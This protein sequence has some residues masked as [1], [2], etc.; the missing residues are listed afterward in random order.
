[1]SSEA[2]KRAG[3]P[4]GVR[5]S[6]REREQRQA[7]TPS[8]EPI[9]RI[10]RPA[11]TCSASAI[12]AS[13]A[14]RKEHQQPA[15]PARTRQ[16]GEQPA[17]EGQQDHD[18]R[19]E[20]RLR[21]GSPRLRLHTRVILE[22]ACAVAQQASEVTA[23]ARLKQSRRPRSRRWRGQRARARRASRA[24]PVLAP[25]AQLRSDS[26]Q[27]LPGRTGHARGAASISAP[28][29]ERPPLRA[30]SATAVASGGCAAL[31]VAAVP[32]TAPGLQHASSRRT[33]AG[34]RRA[35][36]PGG[37][38]D[39][40]GPAGDEGGRRPA[41]PRGACGARR[42]RDQRPSWPSGRFWRGDRQQLGPSSWPSFCLLVQG[43]GVSRC[44]SQGRDVNQSNNEGHPEARSFCEGQNHRGHFER[45][46]S[47]FFGLAPYRGRKW[48]LAGSSAARHAHH[49]GRLRPRLA[50]AARHAGLVHHEVERARHLLTHRSMWQ[51]PR[52]P[53]GPVLRDGAAHRQE[54]WRGRW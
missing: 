5:A 38:A 7:L 10:A 51:R 14:V 24:S 23:G 52:R 32:L 16:L 15:Q 28:L 8:C 36:S 31:D 12:P 1:M 29:S 20:A 3:L 18:Q 54:S 6:A 21:R 34:R 44:G 45:T 53:S 17:A 2:K 33:R 35:A 4:A 47:R 13:Q 27:F 49:L 11:A 48:D 26:A 50:L 9:L 25:D 43:R 22:G 46:P 19:R 37:R 40:H 41:R 39:E 30:Q 42:C